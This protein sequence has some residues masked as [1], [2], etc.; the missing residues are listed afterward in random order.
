MSAAEGRQH[1]GYMDEGVATIEVC[2]QLLVASLQP[3]VQLLGE[4][5]L[6]LCDHVVGVEPAEALLQ[7]DSQQVGVA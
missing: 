3:V 4:A 7:R 2:E 6:D 1:V 5:F